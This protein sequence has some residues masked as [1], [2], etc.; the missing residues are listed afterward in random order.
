MISC[1]ASGSPRTS[2]SLKFSPSNADPVMPPCLMDT[3]DQE[4]MREE[5]HGQTQEEDFHRRA[6]GGGDQDRENIGGPVGRSRELPSEVCSRNTGSKRAGADEE[7]AG[8]TPS[9]KATLP[10]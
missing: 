5:P 9:L 8:T 1:S 3:V 4:R 7:A 10:R 2:S 6:E